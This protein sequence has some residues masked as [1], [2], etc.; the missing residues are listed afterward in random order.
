MTSHAMMASFRALATRMS[1]YGQGKL[2]D[3]KLVRV[4]PF[5]YQ[6]REHYALVLGF[7]SE[8]ESLMSAS[9]KSIGI[10][11]G[12]SLSTQRGSRFTARV[13]GIVELMASPNEELGVSF[14]WQLIVTHLKLSA[15]I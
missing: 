7:Q 9:D 4:Q 2:S 8:Q 6:S 10:V 14:M 11:H 1:K 13:S 5:T 12:M 15:S 3:Q